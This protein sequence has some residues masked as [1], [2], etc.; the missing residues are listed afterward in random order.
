MLMI[1]ADRKQ[2]STCVQLTPGGD[3]GIE[4]DTIKQGNSVGGADE[5]KSL[6][7]GWPRKTSMKRSYLSGNQNRVGR[8][9][10]VPER[11]FQVTGIASTRS[12]KLDLPLML[13]EERE[14][15]CSW[16]VAIEA[17]SCREVT[18]ERQAEASSSGPGK[19][20]HGMTQFVPILVG[21]QEF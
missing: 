7:K 17:E 19:Q 13:E 8:K 16:N 14:G 21:N 18:R 4:D 12:L 5:P 15:P 2:T 20:E 1:Q 3:G 6:R 11:A 9:A 10:C